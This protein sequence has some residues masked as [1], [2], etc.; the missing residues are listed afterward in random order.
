MVYMTL[1]CICCG[2]FHFI[3]YREV[4][5][6]VSSQEANDRFRRAWSIVRVPDEAT[7]VNLYALYL[8]GGA[9]FD[10][11]E[12]DFVTWCRWPLTE[13]RSVPPSP[14]LHEDMGPDNVRH[15]LWFSNSTHRGGWSVMYDLDRKRAWIYYSPR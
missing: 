6:D 10:I 2:C 12:K 14:P 15:C 5:T 3:T 1:F 9:D 7:H 4:A 11:A 8:G 13:E